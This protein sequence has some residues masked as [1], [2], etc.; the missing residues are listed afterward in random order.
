MIARLFLCL[1]VLTGLSTVA[2][3]GPLKAAPS[4]KAFTVED[5]KRSLAAEPNA[6]TSGSR[7]KNSPT[8]IFAE[9]KDIPP[10]QACDMLTKA[11][12]TTGLKLQSDLSDSQ[13]REAQMEQRYDF[14]RAKEES[15]TRALIIG[16]SCGGCG[17]AV[18]AFFLWGT[19]KFWKRHRPI[20]VPNKQLLTLLFIAMWCSVCFLAQATDS[21]SMRHPINAAV[22]SLFFASPAVLFGGIAFWWFSPRRSEGNKT[23]N[24]AV[25]RLW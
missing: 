22:T 6:Q 17:L 25:E 10:Q 8:Q 1:L 7:V 19:F 20:K 3:T 18:T 12:Y 16:S 2:Q 9:G 4:K 14:I 13:V 23:E 5:L 21:G 11:L 15:K 24:P